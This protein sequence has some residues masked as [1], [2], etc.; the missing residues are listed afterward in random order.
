MAGVVRQPIDVKSLENYIQ[1]NVPEI[2]IPLNLKQ[3]RQL[4]ARFHH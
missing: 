3:V 4:R 1:K 2:Q